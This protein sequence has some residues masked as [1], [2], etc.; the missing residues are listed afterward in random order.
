L[1]RILFLTVD[2]A[3]LPKEKSAAGGI[4]EKSGERC[5]EM[6]LAPRADESS[7]R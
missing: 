2:F 3:Q 7:E 6:A 5:M 1:R 4:E